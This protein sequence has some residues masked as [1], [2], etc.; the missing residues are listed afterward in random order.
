V[1]IPGRSLVRALR[2]R[3]LGWLEARRL[4]EEARLQAAEEA[5]L[6]AAEV[7]RIEQMAAQAAQTEQMITQTKQGVRAVI[8][9]GAVDD[10]L[11]DLATE[12]VAARGAAPI[13]ELLGRVDPT[14]PERMLTYAQEGEDLLLMRMLEGRSAG[15]FVDVGAHHPFRFSNT[16]LFYQSGWRGINID[17]TPGSM[18]LFNQFRPEDIN[19]ES[20]VGQAGAEI[21]LTFYN[22]PALN[23]GSPATLETRVLPEHRYWKTGTVTLTAQS[24]SDILDRHLP[25]G[26]P[27]VFLTI[28]VEGAELD[29]LQS[30][31]L[32]RYR[33]EMI[34]VELRETE[35]KDCART[36]VGKLLEANGY[37]LYA[38]T[39]NMA[40]F[41]QGG[42]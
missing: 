15:F 28:D 36:D 41:V 42:A 39:Y 18:A 8:A 33:P 20:F 27:I 14:F 25:P 6:Q 16:W 4:A 29:V 9:L 40:F 30:L 37:R 17:A 3:Y 26:Q 1:L 23:T 10:E 31:D 11:F 19:L 24:L 35:L 38:K 21:T 34:L 22:E 32:Q 12:V 13:V 2:A 5:R 7:A